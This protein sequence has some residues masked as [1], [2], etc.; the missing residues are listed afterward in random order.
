MLYTFFIFLVCGRRSWC[1]FAAGCVTMWHSILRLLSQRRPSWVGLQCGVVAILAATWPVPSSICFALFAFLF[2]GYKWLSAPNVCICV[3][4]SSW[5]PCASNHIPPTVSAARL[6][7]DSSHTLYEQQAQDVLQ[8][9]FPEAFET[10][11]SMDVMGVNWAEGAEQEWD[12]SCFF[13]GT[14]KMG[15]K[16]P[17]CVLPLSRSAKPSEP[18]IQLAAREKLARCLL[19]RHTFVLLYPHLAIVRFGNIAYRRGRQGAESCPP[20][21]QLGAWRRRCLWN[22]VNIF[23]SI[24]MCVG[25]WSL[26]RWFAQCLT[27]LLSFFCCLKH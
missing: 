12:H 16:L 20:D 26:V 7:A 21:C 3:P 2:G 13:V 22:L 8:T 18:R 4:S 11:S 10:E 19:R 17:T 1:G 24:V 23:F 15:P 6:L 25:V 27:S 9:F 5:T 14:G